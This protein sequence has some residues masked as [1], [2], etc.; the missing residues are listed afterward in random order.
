MGIW[1]VALVTLRV[2]RASEEQRSSGNEFL[3]RVCSY[4]T[5]RRDCKAAFTIKPATSNGKSIP[6]YARSTGLLP[7]SVVDFEV[8]HL[9]SFHFRKGVNRFDFSA[10]VT[11]VR[12]KIFLSVIPERKT[13]SDT[14]FSRVLRVFKARES[15]TSRRS[16]EKMV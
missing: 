9:S 13:V 16:S 1:E 15:E 10:S 5:Q 3:S 12:L 11:F 2:K 14:F 6:R 8:F 7:A 4:L